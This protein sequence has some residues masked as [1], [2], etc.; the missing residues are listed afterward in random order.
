MPPSRSAARPQ[1]N[2]PVAPPAKTRARA[3]PT[4]ATVAPLAMSANGRDVRNAGRVALSVMPRAEAARGPPPPPPAAQGGRGRRHDRPGDLP[5][6]PREVVGAERGPAKTRLV[7]LRDERRGER[8]LD[9]RAEAGEQ[10][11]E[12]ERREARDARGHAEAEGRQ[13]GAGGGGAAL[14]PAPG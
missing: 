10:E 9:A 6:I 11:H 13:R 1:T 12:E 4:P 7:G 2:L 8:V 5:E 3:P 14:G